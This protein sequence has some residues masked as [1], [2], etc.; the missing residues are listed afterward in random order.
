[1]DRQ[2][3]HLTEKILL[4]EKDFVVPAKKLWLKLSLMGKLDDVHFENF[5]TMLKEDER[6]EVFDNRD[7]PVSEELDEDIEKKGFFEGPQV[8]LKSRKP[9]RKELGN[10]MIK[11]TNT[12]YVSLKKAWDQRNAENQ[13]EEDQ[14]LQALAS[15]QKLL[16]AL[17]K[18][19]PESS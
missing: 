9:T 13:D 3:I 7:T 5:T 4:D 11:K 10:L 2:L 18:E 14:L 6:F 15:T 12:I 1:M 8:M 16:R 17:K 19:F